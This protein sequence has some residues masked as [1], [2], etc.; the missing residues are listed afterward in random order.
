MISP[1]YRK[2]FGGNGGVISEI[3]GLSAVVSCVSYPSD[4]RFSAAMRMHAPISSQS[5][6]ASAWMKFY[7]VEKKGCR[8]ARLTRQCRSCMDAPFVCEKEGK[9]FNIPTYFGVR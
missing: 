5:E 7:P 6:C 8:G 3:S 1:R 4:T 2:D 9:R